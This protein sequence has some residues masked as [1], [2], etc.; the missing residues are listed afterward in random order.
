MFIAWDAKHSVSKKVE[1]E[2]LTVRRLELPVVK[3]AKQYN[4]K[5]L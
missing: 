5:K 2:Q 4:L 1:Q 3:V